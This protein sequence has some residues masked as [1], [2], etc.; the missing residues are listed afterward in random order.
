MINVKV[1][2]FKSAFYQHM[3]RYFSNSSVSTISDKLLLFY[4]VECGLKYLI[5]I[6]YKKRGYDDLQDV[7]F[8]NRPIL[9]QLSGKD[10]HDIIKLLKFLKNTKFKLNDLL[11]KRLDG[12]GKPEKICSKEYNQ[13]WRYGIECEEQR[14]IEVELVLKDIIKYIKSEIV[15]NRIYSGR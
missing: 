6:L 4:S 9:E 10:G 7:L 1:Q 11:T 3:N 15:S 12:K 13:A 8:E 2:D 5:L 14:E